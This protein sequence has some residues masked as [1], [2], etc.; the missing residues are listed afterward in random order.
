MRE[1]FWEELFLGWRE[2]KRGEVLSLL[3]FSS[4]VN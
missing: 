4:V 3:W 1:D 2:R